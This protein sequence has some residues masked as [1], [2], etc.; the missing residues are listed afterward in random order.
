MRSV[1]PKLQALAL[2][3]DCPTD[4]RP[5][6]WICV[7][8]ALLLLPSSALLA[9]LALL[10]AITVFRPSAQPAP[11]TRPE[12]RWLLLLSLLMLLGSFW[13]IRG[14]V[15]WLGLFNWI[16]FFWFYLAIQPY[17][18]TDGSRW[19]LGQWLIA[20]TV[21]VI[22]VSLLQKL[23]GWSELQQTLWGLIRWPMGD[24]QRGASLF[25]NPNVTGA[26]LVITMPFLVAACVKH[27]P[28]LR[29]KLTALAFTLSATL[30]LVVIASR[31][32][33]APLP[34]I[35]FLSCGRRGRQA[36]LLVSLAYG[37]LVFLKLQGEPTA[38]LTPLLD[39]AV[40]DLMIQKLQTMLQ[41][42]GTGSDLMAAIR[43]PT[44][45]AAAFGYIASSPWVGL[46]ENGFGA[47]YTTDQ[48]KLHAGMSLGGTITHSHNLLLEFA[49]SH[50][51]PA[52]LILVVV[53]GR[54]LLQAL[55]LLQ[56]RV[57]S[58]DR[59]WLLATLVMVWVHLWDLPSFDSRVNILDWL[60]VAAVAV[61]GR[62][63]SQE[64]PEGNRRAAQ[65]SRDR[66]A[67]A[68]GRPSGV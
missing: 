12:S 17:L 8:L 6:G 49:L 30:A 68:A 9:G 41:G 14:W 58:L 18:G 27:G 40:P 13:A 54:P 15:A 42:T 5:A 36:V 7:Q 3:A 64:G 66:L 22:A 52:L 2:R 23:F 60:L 65:H 38:A 56:G 63:A 31:N 16:P 20:G 59:A 45:Y 46:G 67:S 33:L 32:A 4:C 21:P 25:D 57:Q 34:V 11:L 10:A 28:W 61:I 39:L 1:L 62:T 44:I 53:I 19:R 35:W 26:W 24:P 55:P 47:L 51:L 43:R 48:F 50:G 37:A 29:S